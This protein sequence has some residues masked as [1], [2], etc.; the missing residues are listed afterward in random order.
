MGLHLSVTLHCA[1]PTL[2]PVKQL[3]GNSAPEENR[4]FAKDTGSSSTKKMSKYTKE[5]QLNP[6]YNNYCLSSGNTALQSNPVELEEP[7]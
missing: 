2:P 3:S 7:W 6:I 5:V 1:F 4:V